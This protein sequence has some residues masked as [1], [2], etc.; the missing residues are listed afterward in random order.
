[1]ISTNEK[2]NM[3][4][5]FADGKQGFGCVSEGQTRMYMDLLIKDNPM[6]FPWISYGFL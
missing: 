1:M 3:Y 4:Y 5:S 6:D 2:H